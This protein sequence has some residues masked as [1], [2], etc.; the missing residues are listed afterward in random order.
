MVH[1]TQVDE[2]PASN[3]RFNIPILGKL[4]EYTSSM[5]NLTSVDLL[6]PADW[7]AFERLI[8]DLFE[9]EWQ[10]DDAQAHGRS[11]QEQWGVDVYGTDQR[12]NKFVGIQCKGRTGGYRKGLKEKELREEVEK[13]KKF[14]PRIQR[15][16]LATTAPN[17][18]NLQKVA[19]ELS[20]EHGKIGLFEVSVLS[21][22]ELKPILDRHPN[23]ALRHLSGVS[24]I[25]DLQLTEALEGGLGGISQQ[26]SGIKADI[27]EIS[28]SVSTA[29]EQDPSDDILGQRITDAAD[30]L[31]DSPPQS[32]INRL[33]KLLETEGRD[34]S[35]RN[36]FRIKANLGSAYYAMGE[37]EAAV[38][39]YRQA[40]DEYPDTSE[41]ISILAVAES[42]AGNREHAA[43]L[44]KSA[45]AK[46]SPQQRAAG[47]YLETAPPETP[48]RDLRD[49]IP[50]QFRRVPEFLLVLAEHAQV[51]GQTQDCRQLVKDAVKRDPENWRVRAHAGYLRFQEVAERDD[52][53]S[54]RLMRKSD[55]EVVED[56]RAHFLTA[57]GLLK[58]RGWPREAETCVM[59]ALSASLLLGDEAKVEEL[60]EQ[61]FRLCG[62]T[63]QLLRFRAAHHMQKG[64]D[65]AVAVVLSKIPEDDRD[66]NDELMLVQAQI[67]EGD[68]QEALS[69]ADALYRDAED[70]ELRV[71]FGNCRM[72][73]AAEA[74]SERFKEV[75]HE[76]LTEHPDATLL[77]ACF[78]FNHPGD[79]DDPAI[80]DSLVAAA[81]K[82]TS[83][84]ARDRAAHALAKVGRHSTA[85]DI[86]LSLC[87]PDT[88]TPQLRM[89]LQTLI[90]SRRIREAKELY[91]KIDTSIKDTENMRRIGAA[92]FQCAGNLRGAQRE[93]EGIFGKEG[94][95]LEDRARWIDICER[96]SDTD[97]ITKYLDTVS[98][99]V[100][101]D[102]RTR[103]HIA[104]K[105]DHYSDRFEAALEIGYRALR[106][107]YDDPLI[108]VGYMA[109][110][111]LTGRSGRHFD[112]ERDAVAEDTAVVISRDHA[113][114]FTR[115][116]ETAP[117]PRSDRDEI[118][119]EDPLAQ[120]LIGKVVGD[121]FQ[122][123]SA[124]GNQNATIKKILSKYAYA[125]HR[126]QKD[127]ERLFPES[128]IFGALRFDKSDPE[129][130]FR[131]ILDSAR[132]RAEQVDRIEEAYVS[133]KAP[134]ALLASV[135]G[136]TPFDFWDFLRHHPRVKVKMALGN[137]VER[138]NAMQSVL[139]APALI[140]DPITLYGAQ[141]LGFA[142]SILQAYPDL[143]ITQS[144]I[145]LLHDSCHERIEAFG[146]PGLQGK[147]VADDDA[148]RVVEM[149]QETSNLLVSNLE[150]T[151]ELAKTLKVAMPEEGTSLNPDFEAVF[152]DVG[153]C[154]MDTLI[155]AKERG[156]TALIDDTAM[157]LIANQEGVSS[158]WSQAALQLA[159][160]QG[161]ITQDAYSGAVG[162]MLEGNYSY[163]SID[164]DTAKFEWRRGDKSPW[165]NSFI[166]QIALPTND[167]WSIAQ[168]IGS[169]L[170]ELWDD[171]DNGELCGSY[172]SFM[173]EALS[174][175]LGRESG[176]KTIRDAVSAAVARAQR[177]GRMVHLPAR[178]LKTTH[179]VS[180]AFL[181]FD[182]NKQNA[183]V[184]QE[185]VGNL[186]QSVLAATPAD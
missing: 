178:L 28:T 60:L 141:C 163:V 16:I 109:D 108:H 118:L 39:W 110:L 57:W 62:D 145:D 184:I 14:E 146:V 76:V 61:A 117:N 172:A 183:D 37:K 152:E 13:A 80:T 116:I 69:R 36:R 72:L 122:M 138:N 168:L 18:A 181:A 89:A 8:R 101:G 3:T 129:G 167:P 58:D 15:F 170:L 46:P 79:L 21:W 81:E 87:D 99:D 127:F 90:N 102:P 53:R 88:D 128:K 92:I 96:L 107:G 10:T 105:I 124:V 2:A 182:I 35:D 154:F 180:P 158:A 33:K 143:H 156:W 149:S 142:D 41:G 5:V 52:I 32:S 23:V 135:G 131:P 169:S 43:E 24:S 26:L 97:A 94:E 82:E 165:L 153:P 7:Q 44:A 47:V 25:A 103:M 185:T 134:M 115:I 112:F 86:Y 139:N 166:D 30:L 11:G 65:G 177:N 77:L 50:K 106:D 176:A 63:P 120:R 93:L 136:G 133:G 132:A 19:R 34:A 78:V 137:A 100:S 67:Y 113:D 175:R 125:L 147:F 42:I 83:S 31:N 150:K 160:N 12:H 6:P 73:A 173:F 130:S 123:E 95:A 179:L 144:S 4:R 119:P 121:I 29:P 38:E 66:P 64:E 140:I 48:W 20:E 111:I 49:Q 104:H 148:M 151:L 84:I 75:A 186:V 27:R 114:P 98:V 126:S 56:A 159:R 162:V 40:H 22:D 85:A 51:A 164:G 59:N 174:E 55:I 71:A 54:L 74:G 70:D 157:R 91:G 155:V 68:P 9:S 1:A 17:D 45:L 161:K 171:E